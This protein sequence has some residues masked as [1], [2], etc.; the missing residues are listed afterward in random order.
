MG[1]AEGGCESGVF[2]AA[3]EGDDFGVQGGGGVGG[4]EGGGGRRFD[5][6]GG[7]D[8]DGDRD[9]FVGAV[10]GGD[11]FARLA[12]AEGVHVPDGVEED[13]DVDEGAADDVEA[14]AREVL[15][16]LAEGA[17]EPEGDADV[18]GQ[19]G[20]HDRGECEDDPPRD[21]WREE[22]VVS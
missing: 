17:G 21:D 5:V 2:G 3:D 7:G 16:A 22:L 14:A 6:G 19:R 12:P 1:G 18:V 9:G 8:G 10:V 13:G 15:D 11:D 20:D 4:A